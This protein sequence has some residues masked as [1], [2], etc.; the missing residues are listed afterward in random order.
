MINKKAFLFLFI[1]LFLLV[2]FISAEELTTFDNVKTYDA[3]EQKVIIENTFGIGRTIADITLETEWC[4]FPNCELKD[5]LNIIVPRGYQKVAQFKINT[6]DTEYT[7][8]LEKIEF[9]D[10]IQYNLKQEEAD[11]LERQFDY[12]LLTYEEMVVNDYT[13]ECSNFIDIKNGSKTNLCYETINGSHIEQKEKW[14][15]FDYNLLKEGT[16]TIGLFTDVKGGD[17]V[18]YIP[19]FYGVKIEEWSSWTES[20]KVGVVVHLSFEDANTQ[21]RVTN[22]ATTGGYGYA[23]NTNSSMWGEGKFGKGFRSFYVDSWNISLTNISGILFNGDFTQ[24]AWYKINSMGTYQA[25]IEGQWTNNYFWG[26]SS[27][28]KKFRYY[29]GQYNDG[30]GEL[31]SSMNV[32]NN[33]WMYVCFRRD[34]LN[35]ACSIY[36]N[37]SLDVFN[38]CSSNG[39]TGGK[40][41]LGS[42]DSGSLNGYIDEWDLWNRSL[43]LAE[44]EALWNNGDGLMWN[45]IT[46]LYPSVILNSPENYFNTTS[47][48]ITFNTTVLDYNLGSGVANVSLY[49]DNSLD[50]I[51]TSGV[52]GTY[53]FTKVLG[54][55]IH[56]WSIIAYNN[57]GTSNQ[58]STR[59]I[60]LTIESPRIT[61]LYPTA[62]FNTTNTT[63]NFTTEVTDNLQ[64]QNV[65]IYLDGVLNQTNTSQTNGTYEFI[66]ILNDGL[67]YWSI[68]AYDNESNPSQSANRYF[69]IDTT[70]FIQF[71][72]P[73][74]PN[75]ANVTGEII[76]MYVNVSTPYFFNISYDIYNINGSN[77]NK[78]YENETYDYN[79]TNLPD[80]HYHYN[81][82][83]C[84]TT[85]RCNVTE[86]RHLNHDVTPPEINITSP[87]GI[88][89]YLYNGRV[90][91]LNFTTIDNVANVSSCWYNYNGT[92]ISVTC[93]N[94]TLVSVPFAL[95]NNKN[96]L[97]VYSNDTFGNIGFEFISWNYK[98]L[99]TSKEY[100]NETLEG[101]FETFKLYLSRGSG[102]NVQSVVLHYVTQTHTSSLFSSGSETRA[103][104]EL[105]IDNVLAD[106]NNT[107]YFT[108]TLSDSTVFNTTSAVQLVRNVNL[109][110]CSSQP[111]LFLNLSLVDEEEQTAILGD[112]QIYLSILNP[113]NFEEVL[114]FNGSYSN[115]SNK[116]FCSNILLNQ[117]SFL[118]GAKIRYDSD[119]HSAEFYNIQ[120]SNLSSYPLT[121]VLYDL[122]D[123]DTT[124]FKLI[125][126]GDNLIGVVDAIIQLQRE[127][128]PEGVY[129]IVEAPLTSSDSTAV[130]HV[131]TNTNSYRATVVKNG[132]LLD[133]FE[134][135]AFICQSELT[136]E[137]TLDLQDFIVPP[138]SIT[139]DTIQDFSYSI[140]SDI[141]NKT[142]TLD[143]SVPTGT[144][145]EIRIVA[146]Q[147]DIVG[148]E[149]ICNT[150]V[151]S[152]GGSIECEYEE[153]I[154]D[155]VIYY[156][157]YKDGVQLIQKSYIVR[158][159][160]RDDFGGD[161]YFILII[162]AI[163]LIFMAILSPEW[164]V[165]N[166]II[167]IIIGGAT[168][169]IRGMD[170]VLGLG[171]IAWLLLGAVIIIIKLSKKEDE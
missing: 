125:Y 89:D 144:N 63:I 70:P 75:Y 98:I 69:T 115:V 120:R 142:I 96:N 74:F 38:T 24:C 2:P 44:I 35:N 42:S 41:Y 143:Y 153:S 27:D 95:S 68:L 128:I 43:S 9:Y 81:V 130:V 136:G 91:N 82:T 126:R 137:C 29:N 66:K 166:S 116:T 114:S 46:T 103:E 94:G 72:S 5:N 80:A 118:L 154:D 139:I 64:V 104:S 34:A 159:D 147:K 13:V 111:Y 97:T 119:N 164:I 61:L 50:T 22:N 113:N 14:I 15:N 16:Y 122:K 40:Y 51:N 112:I 17:N 56:N 170:F 161:N 85:G 132:V 59:F 60:N 155:S 99:E 11:L 110:D 92:N 140:E 84:T 45:P 151:S 53:I 149:V 77:F 131:D 57:N 20:L 19:T 133:T 86:T 102:I 54:A 73:T 124:R 6:Y 83:V 146:T 93:T 47:P 150:S 28:G 141:D 105:F 167:S 100:D 90:L 109:D 148:E 145:S 25:I 48:L 163:S 36:I 30:S 71:I 156:N 157:V 7:N 171:A 169:L 55:G 79:F 18:E 121:Y 33:V 1:F 58:S 107:F 78:Y 3:I 52:N 165:L 129:K 62:F 88:Y 31:L 135:L 49:I 168:W 158:D 127:Y 101:N 117:T 26:S 39:V 37:G 32:T 160:L 4:K 12:K 106:T 123:E 134:N 23:Y 8:P 152:A 162:F 10:K 65:S 76:P 67:H 108:V 87:S 21:F 138:N